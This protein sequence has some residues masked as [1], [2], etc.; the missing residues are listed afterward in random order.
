M[1]AGPALRSLLCL[2]IQPILRAELKISTLLPES[3]RSLADATS[4]TGHLRR[5]V[6]DGVPVV[7]ITIKDV[8]VDR[9][10]LLSVQLARERFGQSIE[11]LLDRHADR[12]PGALF[13]PPVEHNLVTL[14]DGQ[15]LLC[16]CL[17]YTSDA[18][19]E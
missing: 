7:P 3:A 12:G 4:H 6:I 10:A 17:L 18:A 8:L 14:Q 15:Q 1:K 5:P 11:R 13:L 9:I 2:W 19:D 16:N